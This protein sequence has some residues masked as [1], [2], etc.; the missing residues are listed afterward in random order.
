MKI[1][2]TRP[3]GTVIEAEGTADECERIAGGAPPLRVADQPVYIPT[4]LWVDP[5][6][7]PNP[8]SWSPWPYYVTPWTA[9][10]LT[11]GGAS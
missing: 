8:P 7:V 9:P 5:L 11:I 2:I 1:K 3:D 4:P 10:T 6:S